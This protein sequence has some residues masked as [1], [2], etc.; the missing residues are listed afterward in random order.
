VFVVQAVEHL[1]PAALPGNELHL[2]QH[3]QLVGHS[4]LRHPDRLD[5]LR[6]GLRTLTQAAEDVHAA[7]SGERLHHLGH[8][9]GHRA[10]YGRPACLAL[11]PMTH[12]TE[13]T[14]ER[15][16]GGRY[17][18]LAPDAPPFW[19]MCHLTNPTAP[20]PYDEEGWGLLLVEDECEAAELALEDLA[21]VV[22]DER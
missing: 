6:D 18:Q 3:P 8:A 7:G 22:V 16:D 4:G 17:G 10:R 12:P 9:L 13:L 1:S 19:G 5:D 11:N 20:D 14:G 15:R 21:G 2:P